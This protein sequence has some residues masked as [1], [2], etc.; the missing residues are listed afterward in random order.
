MVWSRLL[1]PVDEPYLGPKIS[2]YFLVLITA[3]STLRSLIHIFA[4]DGGA[5]SIAGIDIAVEG[6]ENIVAMF[7]QWGASQLLLALFYW[8]VI[9]RY[10]FL[11]PA[12]LALVFLE[13]VFRIGAGLLKPVVV[14]A[15]PPGEIG[16]YIILPLSLAALLLS[17][18]KRSGAS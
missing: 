10:R 16:S 12:A 14:A 1:P 4:A 9:L 11:I 2:F 6:G 15:P 13:Q 7:G 18:R 3:V 5:S 17:L 8:L